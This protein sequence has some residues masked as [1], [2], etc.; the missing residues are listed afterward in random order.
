MKITIT[1]LA[2]PPAKNCRFQTCFLPVGQR[3]VAAPEPDLPPATGPK[4]LEMEEEKEKP[5][6]LNMQES[7]QGILRALCNLVILTGAIAL[8][9]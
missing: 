1:C 3:R 8:T 5:S 2:P 6:E 9:L 7:G 4:N